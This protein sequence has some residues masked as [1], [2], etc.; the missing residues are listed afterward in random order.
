MTRLTG[1]AEVADES[2]GTGWRPGAT[3]GWLILNL[4]IFATALYVLLRV[5]KTG[6]TTAFDWVVFSV[7]LILAAISLRLEL[8]RQVERRKT[9][10]KS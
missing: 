3:A 2:S 10:D 5:S 7:L 1:A 9:Q 4:S 6:L 8:A